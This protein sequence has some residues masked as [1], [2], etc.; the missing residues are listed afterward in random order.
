MRSKHF[1]WYYTK[2]EREYVRGLKIPCLQA[3]LEEIGF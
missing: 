1:E 3:K 2:N